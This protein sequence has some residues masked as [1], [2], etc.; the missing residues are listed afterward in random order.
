M[1]PP[2]LGR[3]VR[4]PLV[5][6]ELSKVF[7]GFHQKSEFFRIE[8]TAGPEN[9]AGIGIPGILERTANAHRHEM[10]FGRNVRIEMSVFSQIDNDRNVQ[11]VTIFLLFRSNLTFTFSQNRK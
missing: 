3:L 11:T 1:G 8:V 2:S 4:K 9:R 7:D 10:S 6:A 5:R